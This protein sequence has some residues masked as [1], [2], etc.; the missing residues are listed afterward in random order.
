MI[1]SLPAA[2]AH[3]VGPST[4]Q[5]ERVEGGRVMMSSLPAAIAHIVVP[6]TQQRRERVEGGV[7]GGVEEE[8]GGIVLAHGGHNKII[9]Y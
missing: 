2:I 3:V 5:R 6:T 7:E 8:V 1:S 9:T 4:Q